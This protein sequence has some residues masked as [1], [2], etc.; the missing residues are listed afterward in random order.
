[1]L[2]DYLFLI[3]GEH[4][5]VETCDLE[6]AFEILAKEGFDF[7]LD[8][9]IYTGTFYTPHQAEIIGYDTY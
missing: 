3:N 4:T 7:V 8:E 5:F 2:K 9:V 1:M 6:N